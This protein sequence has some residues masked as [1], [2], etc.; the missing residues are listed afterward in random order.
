MRGSIEVISWGYGLDIFHTI[1][2]TC[3]LSENIKKNWFF[4]AESLFVEL[5]ITQ[6]SQEGH[7]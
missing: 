2:H 7:F 1:T 5:E 4:I 6:S 3:L